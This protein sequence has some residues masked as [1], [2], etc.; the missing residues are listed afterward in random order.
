[1]QTAMDGFNHFD[2]FVRNCQ[3]Q[4]EPWIVEQLDINTHIELNNE[5]D[6]EIDFDD[7]DKH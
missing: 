1:M 2:E 7:E 4:P 5:A 3:I 6:V